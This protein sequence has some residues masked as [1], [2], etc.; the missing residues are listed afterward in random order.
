MVLF[1]EKKDE[2]ICELLSLQHTERK[3]SVGWDLSF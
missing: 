3:T 2:G 1:S